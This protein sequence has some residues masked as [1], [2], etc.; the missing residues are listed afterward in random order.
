MPVA[1][2]RGA[3]QSALRS[4]EQM[5]IP[6]CLKESLARTELYSSVALDHPDRFGFIQHL[7][8]AVKFGLFH[9][10]PAGIIF[11]DA[12]FCTGSLDRPPWRQEIPMLASP[13][14]PDLLDHPDLKTSNMRQDF[15]NKTHRGH[16]G[17]AI[18]I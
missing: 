5:I 11:Y 8:L 1:S 10:E 2:A 7:A 4:A 16:H 9:W 15:Q 3:P 12:H 18:I 13:V 6:R 17:N 14:S